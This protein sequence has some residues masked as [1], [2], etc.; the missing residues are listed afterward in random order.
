[1]ARHKIREADRD[2][3]EHALD[4]LRE[5]GA[6]VDGLVIGYHEDDEDSH[7]STIFRV[8]SVSD[9]TPDAEIRRAGIELLEGMARFRY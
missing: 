3:M 7:L 6:D 1:M 2:L 5:I 4:I 9:R 8:I